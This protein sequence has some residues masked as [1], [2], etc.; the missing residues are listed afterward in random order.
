MLAP[1]PVE[2]TALS[3]VRI[4]ILLA[5]SCQQL[6]TDKISG[7]TTVAEPAIPVSTSAWPLHAGVL[8]N[9]LLPD[10]LQTGLL[11]LLLLFVV[12]K[13]ALKAYHQWDLERT[14]RCACS[15]CPHTPVWLYC[16]DSTACMCKLAA[17]AIVI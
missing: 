6:T 10:W 8:G 9:V 16:G 1:I 11:T 14:M 12:Y 2:L 17:S 5:G 7:A 3:V 4:Y 13:T 15:S